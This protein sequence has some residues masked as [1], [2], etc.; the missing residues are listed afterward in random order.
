MYRRAR[1]ILLPFLI[2]RNKYKKKKKPPTTFGRKNRK[3]RSAVRA[4]YLFLREISRVKRTRLKHD[5]Y[6]YI[7]KIVYIYNVREMVIGL[8]AGNFRNYRIRVRR[9]TCFFFCLIPLL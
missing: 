5:R 4:E 7:A 6:I 1:T 3:P 2:W 9:G 8:V